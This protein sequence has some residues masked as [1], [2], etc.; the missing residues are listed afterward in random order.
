MSFS[1]ARYS[2]TVSAHTRREQRSTVGSSARLRKKTT[3][4]SAPVLSNCA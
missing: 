1:K 4:S 2:A 3:R